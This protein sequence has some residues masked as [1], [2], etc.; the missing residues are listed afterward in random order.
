MLN[1][2]RAIVLHQVRYGES[3]LIVTLYTEN[4]GRLCCM[5]SGVRSKK[6]RFPSTLFQPLTLL[7]TDFYYRASRDLQRMKEASCPFHYATIPFN[8]TKST[9]AMFLSEILYLTLREEE[10]N[11]TLFSFLFHAFQLLDTR[12]EGIVNFHI[13]FMLIYSRFL[14]ILPGGLN[15][16]KED[17]VSPDL[18]LFY[19]LP[20]EAS[21]A[22]S[23]FLASPQGPP[24]DIRL[25]HASRTLLLERLI[26]HYSLH[27]D[28][29]S[30][31]KSFAVLRE[32]F[33]Q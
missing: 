14:G 4:H 18:Q 25:S 3:S 12:E 31:L 1:K 8:V 32:V 5:V 2:T 24:P 10:S 26:R 21:S 29:F 28:G 27:L 15:P 7:E 33:G 16:V 17:T 9:M 19:G 11:P 20:E 6:S 13:W 22:L 23:E 30:R